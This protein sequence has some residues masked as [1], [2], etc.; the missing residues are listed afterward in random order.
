MIMLGYIIFP[1]KNIIRYRR[2]MICMF[3]RAIINVFIN[4]G[5]KIYQFYP[6][7]FTYETSSLALSVMS[8]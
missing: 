5:K 8:K 3:D 6:Y 1:C 2:A 4:N 7:Q